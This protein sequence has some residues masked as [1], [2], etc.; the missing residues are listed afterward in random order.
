VIL[1]NQESGR[2]ARYRKECGGTRWFAW[3]DVAGARQIARS[4]DGDG[5]DQDL[6][7]VGQPDPPLARIDFTSPAAFNEKTRGMWVLVAETNG[8]DLGGEKRANLG[9]APK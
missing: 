1:G 2:A 7:M 4:A 3:H 6:S 8:V 5:V 9:V